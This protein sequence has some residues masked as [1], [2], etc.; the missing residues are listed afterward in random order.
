[1]GFF[2]K[3]L[4]G[5]VT[6]VTELDQA[7]YGD[8]MMALME[9]PRGAS[10]ARFVGSYDTSLMAEEILR[11]PVEVGSF[12]PFIYEVLY[13]PGGDRRISE[14]STVVR[15]FTVKSKETYY[16]FFYCVGDC[17]PLPA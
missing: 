4:Q 2:S 14:P 1:M 17:K 9:V 10:Y 16:L 8:K 11:S 15:A 13:I 5:T 3:Q 6:G 12:F 7:T